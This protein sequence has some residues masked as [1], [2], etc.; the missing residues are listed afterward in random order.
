MLRPSFLKTWERL[1]RERPIAM[2]TLQGAGLAAF[3]DVVAQRIEGSSTVDWR[4]CAMATAA[5]A[6][7]SG[8]FVPVFY[9]ALDTAFPGTGLRAVLSKTASDIAVQGCFVNA[10]L[11]V[12]RGAPASS[13][14]P[15]SASTP[16]PP[17]PTPNPTQRPTLARRVCGRGAQ[18]HAAGTAARLLRLVA[19][20]P[21]GVSD[22]PNPHPADDHGA[23]DTRLEYLPLRRGGEGASGAHTSRGHST[24]LRKYWWCAHCRAPHT[25]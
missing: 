7:L 2:N 18:G 21:L 24:G 12:A 25:A 1:L 19:I 9:R 13:H 15:A 6:A 16:P 11:L 22:D 20:R 10:A 5:G 3:G 14:L 23:D 17:I 4:Q 8:L